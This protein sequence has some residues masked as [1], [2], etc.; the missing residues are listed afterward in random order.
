[1][2]SKK[3][4]VGFTLVL[5][6]V[7]AAVMTSAHAAA[8]TENVLLN[9]NGRDGEIPEAGLIFDA[10]GN[11]YG[12]TAAG[13][14]GDSGH[15]T[16]F[17]LTPNGSGGWSEK[18]LHSFHDSGKDGFYPYDSLV[19]DAAGSL[20]GTTFSGG[21]NDAG[22]VFELTPNA[23]GGWTEKQL[24]SFNSNGKDG[25]GPYGN[26]IFDGAGNLYGTTFYGPS[27]RN[28]GAV[29]ELLPVTG[30]G[31]KEKILL[32]FSGPNGE[33][34]TGGLIF[35]AAGNL[36]GT[37]SEGGASGYGTVFELTPTTGGTWTPTVL[38]NFD[39]Y[40]GANPAGGLI[41][42][43]SGNLY[44]T[45]GEGGSGFGTV[46][47]LTPATGGAWTQRVLLQFNA[48]S[49]GAYPCANL[50]LDAA[51]N[52]YGTTNMGGAIGYG[53]VFELTPAAGGSW[54]ETILYS[55]RSLSGGV[56]GFSPVAGLVRDTA[57]NLYGTTTT[58]GTHQGGAV[59]ELTP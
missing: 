49:E 23:G 1:M 36:Y 21:A 30:G 47:E 28:Y 27:T 29:F 52:L 35:D 13:G 31:W 10:A 42:D 15:G 54:T 17:E 32:R 2:R 25:Y 56:D 8:Q 9:F 24:H 44:G 45:T 20:Y 6:V 43:G 14:T 19:M 51:G 4:A 50:I 34:P 53:T 46:F 18:V 55:F 39:S 59:F 11:L 38:H 41:F 48:G 40:D 5:G 3:V 12:T 37:A 58:G 16:A 33:R 22:T 7:A 26:L 57:G